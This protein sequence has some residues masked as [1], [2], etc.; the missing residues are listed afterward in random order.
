MGW[1]GTSISYCTNCY[2]LKFKSCIPEICTKTNSK[3]DFS[4]KSAASLE[5]SGLYQHFFEQGWSQLIV[6]CPL[7]VCPN[8]DNLAEV[9]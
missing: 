1:R 2:T 8:L 5:A 4:T 6:L 9:R 7:L 3:N